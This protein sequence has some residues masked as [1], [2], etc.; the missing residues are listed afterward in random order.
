MP[1]DVIQLLFEAGAAYPND[2]AL[3]QGDASYSYRE[4]ATN[5]ATIATNLQ[6]RGVQQGDRFL[7]S[8]PANPDGI[9][10]VLGI[11]ASGGVVVFS[12]PDTTPELFD[13]RY[14]LTTPKYAVAE[15][16]LYASSNVLLKSAMRKRV[17]TAINYSKL[18]LKHF[19]A[20]SWLPG[21]PLGG[22][23]INKL[24]KK[25]KTELQ[26]TDPTD[27]AI[28]AFTSGASEKQKVVVHSQASLGSGMQA[29]V[30]L[31]QIDENSLVYTDHF[32]FGV[33]AMTC[34]GQWEIPQGSPATDT[35]AWLNTLM[36]K[37]PTHTFL[38][39]TETTLL[40]DKIERRGGIRDESPLGTLVMNT[41][42]LVP[43]LTRR[44]NDLMP[45][46]S[47]FAVYGMTEVLPS[48]VVEGAGKIAYV[49]G[50]LAG[51]VILGATARIDNLDGEENGELVLS[52]DGLMFGYL[53][54][55]QTG[56]GNTSGNADGKPVISGR[57]KDMLIRGD[58]NIYPGLYEP[59]I[60]QLSGISSCAIVGVPD[61]R[62]ND[63]VVLVVVP[64]QKEQNERR[65]R[66]K[67]EAHLKHVMDL[68][69][70]P[71]V[72][73]VQGEIPLS[74]RS[75]QPNRIQ[76][77]KDVSAHS[78]VEAIMKERAKNG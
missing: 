50:D 48:V 23:S 4:V 70:L 28:I 66:R 43:S 74:G 15:S 75:N 35:G 9:L 56:D 14:K 30:D 68:D 11:V 52:G 2:I 12:D 69:A 31:C 24:L 67:V 58:K 77:R 51:G 16:A 73:I 60:L 76:L 63:I 34:G 61:S 62:G 53:S 71:D 44:V 27:E 36:E 19:Y 22:V 41:S 18:P 55:D 29:F 5:I 64:A 8:V 26:T 38:T 57:R 42:P 47:V 46:T 59:G 17:T 40:L 1:H 37:Q 21:T 3:R 13:S 20:G 39:P 54:D 10:L 78:E 32:M 7:F 25:P 45:G 72:V 6:A 65:L 33:A 49:N